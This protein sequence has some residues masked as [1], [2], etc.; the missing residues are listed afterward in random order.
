MSVIALAPR[1]QRPVPGPARRRP[2]VT[3]TLSIPLGAGDNTRLLEVIRELAAL[4]E[5]QV[6][7]LDAPA[8]PV[9]TDLGGPA[10]EP[11]L[12]VVADP[13]EL[14]VYSG[15]RT[16]FVGPEPLFLTRLEFDLLHFLASN[17]RRV[18]SR[19]QLLS[20]V[21]GYEHAGVR[22]VDVHVRR[23]RMKLGT[24]IPL[25]TTVYGVGY[26]LADDA[27]VSVRTDG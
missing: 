2:A 1:Q 14:T 24:E 9:L 22:T 16:V 18:F 7:V 15:S 11:E 13:A 25:I 17:P 21:W 4:G 10:A 26:R 19:V 3:V 6:S 23:L 8:E 5:A 27:R 20:A 12:R